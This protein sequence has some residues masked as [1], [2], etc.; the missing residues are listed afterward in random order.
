MHQFE[1]KTAKDEILLILV[2]IKY[3]QI[4]CR[5]TIVV[6]PLF[7]ILTKAIPIFVLN[8]IFRY[9]NVDWI[10]ARPLRDFVFNYVNHSLTNFN[11]TKTSA[12]C[13]PILKGLTVIQE[14]KYKLPCNVVRPGIQITKSIIKLSGFNRHRLACNKLHY[15][16]P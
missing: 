11:K 8:H 9:K 14:T 2:R 1:L 7:I 10:P 5:L 4:L 16:V 6:K 3:A 15:E 13:T 12:S